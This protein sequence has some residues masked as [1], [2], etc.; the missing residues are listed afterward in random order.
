MPGARADEAEIRYVVSG[1]IAL[2]GRTI[3][4]T[5][6]DNAAMGAAVLGDE[7]VAVDAVDLRWVSAL[8]YRNET[9]EE[10]GVAAGVLGHPAHGVRWLA[11][12]LFQ[13]GTT[14]AAG[15]V[16]LAGSFTRPVW[17]E[18]GDTVHADSGDLG[19]ITCHFE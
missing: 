9:I 16:L 6:S 3:V 17:V 5:I 19:A 12:K 15:E 1:E 10:T 8:L 2:E 14:L 7:R 11:N 18:R 4:D 13:H